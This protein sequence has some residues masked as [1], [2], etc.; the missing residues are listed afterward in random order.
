VAEFARVAACALALLERVA[1]P[2][3]GAAAPTVAAVVDDRAH[4]RRTRRYLLLAA[5]H[6]AFPGARGLHSSAFQLNV[7]KFSVLQAPISGLT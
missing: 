1:R 3:A 5:A 4:R 6:H 7:S 2:A